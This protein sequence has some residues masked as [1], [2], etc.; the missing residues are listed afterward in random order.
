VLPF[1]VT[2]HSYYSQFLFIVITIHVYYFT[3]DILLKLNSI[4]SRVKSNILCCI[5]IEHGTWLT[6]LKTSNFHVQGLHVVSAKAFFGKST[7]HEKKTS[8]NW[9]LKFNSHKNDNNS[10][11]STHDGVFIN[12]IL[13]PSCW[14]IV[15]GKTFLIYIRSK[16][17]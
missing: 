13:F 9:M 8:Q 16:S 14:T 15:C 3:Q 10:R 6:E 1:I 12:N 17:S 4:H 11:S 5:K 2:F 7:K